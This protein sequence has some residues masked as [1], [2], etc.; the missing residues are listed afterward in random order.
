MEEPDTSSQSG[1]EAALRRKSEAVI[2]GLVV[3]VGGVSMFL[4]AS[5]SYR[6]EAIAHLLAQAEEVDDPARVSVTF[7]PDPVPIPD[8]PPD[9]MLKRLEVWREGDALLM[10]DRTGLTGRAEGDS[11]V[12]GG[13]VE[14]HIRSFARL[15]HIGMAEILTRHDRFVLHGGALLGTGQRAVLVVG[16]S[17][18]GKST[19]VTTALGGGWP[20]LCDDIMVVRPNSGNYE[21][22]GIPRPVT[23]P[24]EAVRAAGLNGL[25]VADPR[26]RLELPHGNLLPG[27]WPVQALVTP[28]HGTKS[29]GELVMLPST[30]RVP[31]VIASFAPIHAP[32]LL[33]RFF[34]HAAALSRL[35][36]FQ[37][38]LDPDPVRRV[39]EA[40]KLLD[41]LRAQLECDPT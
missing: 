35:P 5:D 22:T 17:G 33:R 7:G 21:V 24:V 3:E 26:G 31:H 10:R 23:A 13:W 41:E 29:G 27:W 25:D 18:M 14:N 6:A 12:V 19:L 2:S 32:V 11:L 28:V 36:M 40:G 1:V 30:E 4:R 20:A 38:P 37:I 9:V 39:P 34:S 15:F 8:R 16:G